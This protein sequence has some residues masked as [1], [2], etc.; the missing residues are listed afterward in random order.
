VEPFE[1]QFFLLRMVIALGLTLLKILIGILGYSAFILHEALKVHVP[2]VQRFG[3]T[4]YPSPSA[5][6]KYGRPA[7]VIAFAAILFA[8]IAW[9]YLGGQTNAPLY[10]WDKVPFILLYWGVVVIISIPTGVV[11]GLVEVAK[12]KR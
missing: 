1:S 6:R 4:L 11:L 3:A 5:R 9:V 8:E 7:F 2:K 12:T 10:L